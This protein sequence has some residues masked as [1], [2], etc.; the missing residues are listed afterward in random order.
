[1]RRPRTWLLG[2]SIAVICACSDRDTRWNAVLA[3]CPLHEDGVP[4]VYPSGKPVV[5][6]WEEVEGSDGEPIPL[7]PGCRDPRF[8]FLVR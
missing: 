7:R 8:R 3:A 2:L 5:I 4:A 6:P 1:M